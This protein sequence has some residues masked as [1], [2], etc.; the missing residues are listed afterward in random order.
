[1]GKKNRKDKRKNTSTTQN[2]Q[3]PPETIKKIEKNLTSPQE[4]QDLHIQNPNDIHQENL[5]IQ[6][7]TPNNT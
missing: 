6:E 4:N 7:N 2:V 5:I 3:Q 1:M